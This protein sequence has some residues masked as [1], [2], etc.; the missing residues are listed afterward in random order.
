MWRCPRRIPFQEALE[1][2]AIWCRIALSIW[3]RLLATCD[4]GGAKHLFFPNARQLTTGGRFLLC[5]RVVRASRVSPRPQVPRLCH[6][7]TS[8]SFKPDRGCTPETPKIPSGNIIRKVSGC[9]GYPTWFAVHVF[10][11]QSGRF[12]LGNVAA[13][14]QLF[15]DN[16]RQ[17]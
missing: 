4:T 12:E 3:S 8:A 16:P 17:C 9:F 5:M 1:T 6:S 15:A 10:A 13:G 14:N 2:G 7:S 11:A